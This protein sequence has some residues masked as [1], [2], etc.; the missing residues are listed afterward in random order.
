MMPRGDDLGFV[1]SDWMGTPTLIVTITV[2]C[3]YRFCFSLGP[4]VLF[5]LFSFCFSLTLL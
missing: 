3:N 4:F 2:F 1:E 5:S